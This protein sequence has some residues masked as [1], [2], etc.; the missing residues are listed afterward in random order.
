MSRLIPPLPTLP[1]V[2]ALMLSILSVQGGAAIAKGVFPLVGATGTAGLRI[3]LSALMLLLVFRPAVRRLSAPQWRAVLPYGVVLG[4]MNL[5]FYLALARIPL[6]LA[7]TL[8]FVGP[9][10]LAVAGSRRAL[11]VLWVVLASVGVAMITP[12]S[13]AGVDGLGVLLALLAGA[14]WATYV[15]LGSRVSQVLPSGTGVAIGMG[16]ATL[17]VAPFVLLFGHWNRLTPGGLMLGTALAVLS[18]AIP[19]TL[20]LV[21]LRTLPPKIFGV[22]LSLEPAVAAI[23]GVIFLHEVLQPSQWVAV[24]LVAAASG[25]VALATPKA[26]PIQE[27]AAAD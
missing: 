14:F 11:D 25:G 19:F 15:L 8:E 24:M 17:T 18:S 27:Q 7:V 3:G 22:L 13:G 2:P 10:L 5:L 23:C 6:G 1:A 4:V 26:R 9:L 12:W 20:E 16:V 21:A